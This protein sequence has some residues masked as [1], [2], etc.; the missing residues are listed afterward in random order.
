M[1]KEQCESKRYL[2]ALAKV[3]GL[4]LN[5]RHVHME[6]DEWH[7]DDDS[8]WTHDYPSSYY[9][10]KAE[11]GY[12]NV[13]PILK[14]AWTM[15]SGESP[16]I[17]KNRIIRFQPVIAGE[18]KFC[19]EYAYDSLLERLK[20]LYPTLKNYIATSDM[21]KLNGKTSDEWKFNDSLPDTRSE[22]E[23]M[24]AVLG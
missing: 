11:L 17:D 6:T 21:L 24:C 10:W 3:L 7:N 5:L 1:S 8:L 18:C 9:N 20:K 2:K 22:L 15:Y 13:Y 23:I 16:R 4:K 12:E 19:P 14:D